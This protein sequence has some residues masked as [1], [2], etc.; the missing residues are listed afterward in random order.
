VLDSQHAPE[1]EQ[2]KRGAR[3]DGPR[4]EHGDGLARRD[5][6][7]PAR[8]HACARSRSLEGLSRRDKA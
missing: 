1:A 5:L 6:P 4:A 2:D 8:V 3:T 7:A